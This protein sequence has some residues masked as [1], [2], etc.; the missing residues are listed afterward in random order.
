[1]T[2][3]PFCFH[4]PNPGI[5]QGSLR[6]PVV[7]WLERAAHNG[8]VVGSNPAGPTSGS[9]ERRQRLRLCT[10]RKVRLALKNPIFYYKISILIFWVF[11]GN[12]LEA[13]FGGRAPK[14]AQRNYATNPATGTTGLPNT[15]PASSPHSPC[16]RL[17]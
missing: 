11:K 2:E 3:R 16:K 9:G 6:G 8:V 15:V 7:Q 17:A 12:A 1:M 5:V 13:G 14:I 4:N 10:P